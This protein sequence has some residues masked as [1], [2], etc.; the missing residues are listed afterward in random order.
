MNI[1][2]KSLSDSGR[3]P[4]FRP[5]RLHLKR[6]ASGVQLRLVGVADQDFPLGGIYEL[7]DE[8]TARS[9]FRGVLVSAH[10][11]GAQTT[12]TFVE[13][14]PT[15]ERGRAPKEDS[16]DITPFV[17]E[18]SVTIKTPPA[19]SSLRLTLQTEWIQKNGGLLDLGTC[20]AAAFP[21]GKVNSLNPHL[22][23]RSTTGHRTGYTAL[24]A[25]FERVTPPSTGVLD[26]YPTTMP[27]L[28][29]GKETVVLPRYWF[30]SI[31]KLLWDYEQKRIERLT[32]VLPLAPRG[33]A[34]PLA[35]S[36]KAQDVETLE[37]FSPQRATLADDSSDDWPGE[38]AIS[39]S[40]E[41]KRC[42][43]AP[44]EHS[45]DSPPPQSVH[46][47]CSTSPSS[48]LP[49]PMQ[50]Q[51][52]N[53]PFKAPPPHSGQD[54][55]QE[56]TQAIVPP[57]QSGYLPYVTS[58][59]PASYAPSSLQT[60]PGSASPKESSRALLPDFPE[61]ITQEIA[62]PSAQL[63]RMSPSEGIVR[64]FPTSAA[65]SSDHHSS[66]EAMVSQEEASLKGQRSV[67]DLKNTRGIFESS[68]VDEVAYH[69]EDR[70][71]PIQAHCSSP[72][73]CNVMRE[74]DLLKTT[75]ISNL[76][77]GE[78]VISTSDSAADTEISS[79]E[80]E[81]LPSRIENSFVETA[82]I[83][84]NSRALQDPLP[85]DLGTKQTRLGLNSPSPS[86]LQNGVE[87]QDFIKDA[88][89]HP[90]SSQD[91]LE[92]TSALPQDPSQSVPDLSLEDFAASFLVT[93]S[94][95]QASQQ[96]EGPPQSP[97]PVFP[98]KIPYKKKGLSFSEDAS[99]PCSK[100]TSR[101]WSRIVTEALTTLQPELMIQFSSKVTVTL[102]FDV[103][104]G[105]HIGQKVQL[106]FEGR[107]L[108]GTLTTI[109]LSSEGPCRKA[110]LT[111]QVPP[112][113]LVA[114]TQQ[115]MTLCNLRHVAPLEGL[116]ERHLSL[117]D[118]LVDSVVEND[119]E[120]QFA[121]LQSAH[122][123]SSRDVKKW[124]KAHPTNITLRLRSLKTTRHLT[125]D[126][127]GELIPAGEV[128][129]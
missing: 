30:R 92:T 63:E 33:D 79:V 67:T 11:A 13:R 12:L 60:R 38:L 120:Q 62:Q 8:D 117:H 73:P 37:G 90:F 58:Q 80:I 45:Q 59:T 39:D 43:E 85:Q 125:H 1:L 110:A 104:L 75:T 10:V 107:T 126:L 26:L 103:A 78:K 55:S 66:T 32:L 101:L 27:P 41:H 99:E 72:Q 15:E 69:S 109:D 31:W 29:C 20:L 50:A 94:Q 97:P 22:S 89:S 116:T 106:T 114:W 124:L 77:C 4:N 123:S 128:A 16:A 21:R 76:Q 28:A 68:V 95:Q 86:C 84:E 42:F 122:L 100:T 64:S 111:L 14:T 83:P 44:S 2:L 6:D 91:V 121:E 7:E 24:Q 71:D 93:S 52:R 118:V 88:S 51:P 47:P 23:W 9:L 49:S 25:R 40:T 74:E 102:P 19:P 61:G 57:P 3:V 113:W 108:K 35:L 65:A 54:F 105:L 81:N 115:K 119:A 53:E 36:L 18:K 127:V 87:E 96:Q 112:D 98:A 17:F 46:P 5:T 70:A 34:E 82:S 48:T 56:T 129:Q